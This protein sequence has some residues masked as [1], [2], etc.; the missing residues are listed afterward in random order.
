M[1][2]LGLIPARGGS[3]EVPRKNVRPLAGKPLLAWTI[4][5]ALAARCLDRV[6][7]ST[8][9]DEIAEVGL[10]YH[11]EVPFRRPP[12]LAADE[13]PMLPVV[14][15]AIQ[16][17]EETGD[18]FDAV[19]LLQ[20]TTP[21]RRPED[22]DGCIELLESTV[23]DSVVSVVPVPTDHNP[24]WVYFEDGAGWLRLSTGGIEPISRRQD[25][26]CAYCRDGAVYVTRRDV[27]I[28]RSSLYGDRLAGYH[29]DSGY[30]VN[31]DTLE[32]WARAESTLSQRQHS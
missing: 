23:A 16:C 10:A 14:R 12:E 2:V 30:S 19:C 24:Y 22:I 15:H 4:E 7:V 28:E 5:T 17:L 27:V 3:K 31:V 6:V 26:P 25:L 20:P 11:A 21:F 1:K 9:D 29:T 32:D 18:R 13:T 8:D